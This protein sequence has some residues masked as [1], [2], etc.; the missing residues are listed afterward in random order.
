MTLSLLPRSS[1]REGRDR[2]EILSALI[3]APSF[4]PLL[5][6]D[7]I[8]VPAGHPVFRWDCLATG[9]ERPASGREDLCAAHAVLWRKHR[10]AGG[11]RA[12]FLREAPP[13]GP[14]AVAGQ[15]SCRICPGRP[16][17]SVGTQLCGFHHGRWQRCCSRNGEGSFSG[18]L[19]GQEPLPG[20]GSCLV[21]VC[22]EMADSPLGL[23]IPHGRRY[24]RQGS[25]GG[26]ALPP[27]WGSCS[28]NRGIPAPVTCSD[29]GAF[30]R[31]CAAEPATLRPDQVNLL[32]L[33]PLVRAEIQWGMAWHAAGTP[34][35]QWALTAL[36]RLA[37]FSR[38]LG[39]S[40]LT[41]LDPRDSP[42]KDVARIARLIAG[43]VGNLYTTPEES[44]EEGWILAG[45]FGRRLNVVMAACSGPTLA[46]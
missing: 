11:A 12:A 36:Q 19:A 28:A 8:T 3:S 1:G 5:R 38:A 44:R 27:R 7:I 41:E 46:A 25:P 35:R 42:D 13:L 24:R 45:H 23:C 37:D 29:E 14:G 9:C 17:L 20:Y 30:R 40:S 21:G 34:G 4:D 26:A 18:W 22:P 6:G 39:L 32:G 10:Q 15:L 2:L 33:R 16:A 43:V 31:W